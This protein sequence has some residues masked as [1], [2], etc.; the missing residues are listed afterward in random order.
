MFWMINDKKY[1]IQASNELDGG[2]IY[3]LGINASSD[4]TK[5]VSL[6]QFDNLPDDIEI[7]LHDSLLMNYT[8]LKSTDFEIFLTAG[9]YLD[10]FQ[11]VL[12]REVKI[13]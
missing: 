12:S 3:P 5:T 13:Y 11:I 6:Y 7:Y 4:G 8:D 10:R 2:V 1:V 9:E